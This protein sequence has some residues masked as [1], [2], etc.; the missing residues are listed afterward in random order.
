M[1]AEISLFSHRLQSLGEA[2]LR[3]FIRHF[4][5]LRKYFLH[6]TVMLRP[7]VEL[8]EICELLS[9]LDDC[10][11]DW[12]SVVASY[13][14]FTLESHECEH[15]QF[16]DGF[17]IAIPFRF[18]QRLVAQREVLLSNGM[19][20]LAP[21]QL[22]LILAAVFRK[23]LKY[24]ILLARM[25]QR[26]V[27]TGDD[28]VK[29]LFR[30]CQVHILLAVFLCHYVSLQSFDCVNQTKCFAMKIMLLCYDKSY[31]LNAY[32]NIMS[33]SSNKTGAAE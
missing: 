22:P 14:S 21:S 3:R 31:L 29:Q 13:M 20:L 1:S 15:I 19:A 2:R 30:E 10:C 5:R 25:R 23:W 32:I 4:H 26:H 17:H 11:V 8:T 24:G 12:R 27:T 9:V 16:S 6:S 28:R 7:S 33:S 18:V